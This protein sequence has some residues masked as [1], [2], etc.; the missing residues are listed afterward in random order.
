M[1]IVGQQSQTSDSSASSAPVV[2]SGRRNDGRLKIAGPLSPRRTAELAGRSPGFKGKSFG[3]ESSDGAPSMG[4]SF[5]DLDG[6]FPFP[7][8]LASSDIL[9]C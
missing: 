1:E 9:G 2:V 7:F 5:S 3:K 8:L 4:S 6:R